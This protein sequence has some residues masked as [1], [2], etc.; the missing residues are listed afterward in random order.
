M[1]SALGF[2]N[3][4]N[5]DSFKIGVSSPTNK[6]QSIAPALALKFTLKSWIEMESIMNGVNGLV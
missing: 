1:V 5:K 2:G 6:S 4:A 3:T